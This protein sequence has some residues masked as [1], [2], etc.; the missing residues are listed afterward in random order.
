VRLLDHIFRKALYISF[1]SAPKGKVMRV[2]IT[3][4]G[5]KVATA[6]PRELRDYLK[7]S[8]GEST[9]DK[10]KKMPGYRPTWSFE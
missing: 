6:G 5:G 9:L 2:P 10:A 7:T 8:S 1:G 4:V 3:G